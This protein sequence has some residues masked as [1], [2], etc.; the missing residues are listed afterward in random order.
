MR[1]QIRVTRMNKLHRIIN[2][3]VPAYCH[4]APE[5]EIGRGKYRGHVVLSLPLRLP[6]RDV[7]R[8]PNQGDRPHDNGNNHSQT[9]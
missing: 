6:D 4:R 5:M 1:W 7:A 9:G 3:A 8:P 2:N